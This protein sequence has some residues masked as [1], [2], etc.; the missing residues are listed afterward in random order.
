MPRSLEGK[1]RLHNNK[2]GSTIWNLDIDNIMLIGN[3][4][5]W[6]IRGGDKANF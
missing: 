2:K 6:E 1:L 5:F 4:G 3:Q